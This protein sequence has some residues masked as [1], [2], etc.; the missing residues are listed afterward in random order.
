MDKDTLAVEWTPIDRLFENP[1][2][3]R[4]NEVAVPHVTASL[5]RF[6]WR[7]PVVAKPSGEVIAGNTRL[8]AARKLEMDSVPVVRFQGR[9][10]DALAYG[11]PP[12]A[13]LGL[14]LDRLVAMTL[15]LDNIR[16]L[17]A[18]PKTASASD[19]M[20]AAPST[21]DA[22]NLDEVHIQIKGTPESS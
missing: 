19:L 10:L 22:A 17:I 21:V 15:G 4:L 13:G 9:E 5:R 3:P 16:D 12:H 14:G 6:G 7:Q 8:K 2:N 20:C 11:A 18:F 1:A